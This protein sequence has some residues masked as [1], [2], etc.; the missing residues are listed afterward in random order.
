MKFDTK[1]PYK[2]GRHQKHWFLGV[3]LIPLA[4]TFSVYMKKKK[5]YPQSVNTYNPSL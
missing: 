3:R 4:A 5:Q 1:M 2:K